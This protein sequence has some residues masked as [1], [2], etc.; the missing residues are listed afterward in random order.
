MLLKD[1]RELRGWTQ[2][3]W[4]ERIGK[5][6][7]SISDWE[8]ERRRPLLDDINLISAS[9]GMSADVLLMKLGILLTPPPSSRLPR[10]FILDLLE[11]TDEELAGFASLVHRRVRPEH[12]TR[13]PRK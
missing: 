3:E 5:T 10:E 4:G 7:Q 13:V 8:N 9:L 6:K 12:P 1:A 2:T 11:L